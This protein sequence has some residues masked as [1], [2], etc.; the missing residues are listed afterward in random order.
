MNFS[1]FW[2]LTN[3]EKDKGKLDCP[4]LPEEKAP[5]IS[6]SPLQLIKT[7]PEQRPKIFLS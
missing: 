2:F 6:F 5:K 3:Q 4:T 1:K 7:K